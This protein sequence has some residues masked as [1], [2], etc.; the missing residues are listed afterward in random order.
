M[1]NYDKIKINNIIRFFV[2][3]IALNIVFLF[4]IFKT[5][6]ITLRKSKENFILILIIQLMKI[7]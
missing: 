5:Q 1:N 2:I 3:I 4:I 7:I 6:K